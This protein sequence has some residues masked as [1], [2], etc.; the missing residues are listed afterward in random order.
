MIIAGQCQRDVV[1]VAEVFPMVV[2][3]RLAVASVEPLVMLGEENALMLASLLLDDSRCPGLCLSFRFGAGLHL[4]IVERD[5]QDIAVDEPIADA[6]LARVSVCRVI[7]RHGEE[8][9]LAAVA[10]HHPV[11]IA[12]HI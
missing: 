10:A 3:A 1:L 4:L 6:F 12:D 9:A 5:E 2:P 8:L 11:V 7:V